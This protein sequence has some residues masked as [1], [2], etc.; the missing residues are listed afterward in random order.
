MRKIAA[1]ILLGVLA[2]T[3]ASLGQVP[4]ANP[5][6]DIPLGIVDTIIVSGNQKTKTYV[7][8]NE[9]TLQK[10]SPVTSE[11]MEFDRNRIYSLGLFTS[12]DMVFDS[13]GTQKFLIV[14]V[15]ERWYLIPV[16]IFGFRDGDPKKPFYG[17]GVL[18]SNVSGRNQK[19]FASAVFGYDPSL[20]LSFA[21]PLFAP[22][23]NLSIAGSLSFSRVKNKSVI[24]AEATGDFNEE[25]YNINGTLGKRLSLY[26]SLILNL[27][28]Q[29]VQVEQYRTGHTVSTDGRDDA[30]YATIGYT[31]DSRDLTEYATRGEL[32][33]LYVS[34][35]GFG[36]S[37]VNFTRYGADA[38]GYVPLG[39]DFS[40]AGRILGTIVSGGEVPTYAHAFYGYGDKIRGYQR[41]VFE[42][43]NLFGA[44][45]E[46]RFALFKPRIFQLRGT[47]LP[48]EFTVWRF[49]ISLA[50]FGDTGTTW[51]RGDK[52][53]LNSFASGFGGG[54]H[55]LLPYGYVVRTEYAWNDLLKGQFILDFRASI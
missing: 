2:L 40:L 10:G 49:G 41:T 16:P 37:I 17:A 31:F 48:Q 44:N 34:K 8:L 19:L 38:R 30:L 1:L 29:M 39:P 35:Y 23:D 43:E 26:Q 24:E 55:F 46:L 54:I 6:P 5:Q 13:L 7:I 33:A 27:G 25:H 32:L 15:N 50:L 4:T 12:V 22:E 3:Y 14:E 21:D 20:M 47:P 45:I 18:H 53:G 36:E 51:Y 11:A 9:M 28:F 42:G 52:V